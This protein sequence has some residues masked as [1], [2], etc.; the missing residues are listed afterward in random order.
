M[1]GLAVRPQGWDLQPEARIYNVSAIHRPGT[2]HEPRR[3]T[4]DAWPG[5]ATPVDELHDP[6]A[7][8]IAQVI[9][10]LDEEQIDTSPLE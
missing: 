6:V 2:H 10:G 1:A 7:L 5:I 3:S 4:C 9:V 8:Y